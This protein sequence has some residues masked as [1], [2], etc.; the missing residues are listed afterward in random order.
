MSNITFLPRFVERFDRATAAGLPSNPT[1]AQMREFDLRT[2]ELHKLL[3]QI[4]ADKRIGVVNPD[5]EAE[6][7]HLLEELETWCKQGMKS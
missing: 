5:R 1:A 2:Q 4:L 6:A 3:M 7:D